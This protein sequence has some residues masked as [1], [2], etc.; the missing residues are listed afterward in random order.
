MCTLFNR[1]PDCLCV[2]S[3]AMTSFLHSST[4]HDSNSQSHDSRASL[5]WFRMPHQLST[6]LCHL[7]DSPYMGLSPH[8]TQ[9]TATPDPDNGG[10][11]WHFYPRL[12]TSTSDIWE[13][14]IQVFHL[15]EILK[16]VGVKLCMHVFSG[17]AATVISCILTPGLVCFL[18]LWTRLIRL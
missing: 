13:T 2:L 6:L 10:D 15:V 7:G 11:R 8:P 9:L 5:W 17:C 16:S 3:L 18:S 1:Q 14:S 12:P 4:C